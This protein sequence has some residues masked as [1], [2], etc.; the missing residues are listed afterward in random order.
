[1][2]VE[3]DRIFALT[4]I[5][6]EGLA[7]AALV[8]RRNFRQFP[9]F[10]LYLAWAI[11]VDIAGYYLFARNGDLYT[12]LYPFELVID[13]IFQFGILFE[14]SRSVLRPV[15]RFLPRW[16][17]IALGLLIL[18]LGGAIW[19]IAHQLNTFSGPYQNLLR[20]E[21]AFSILRILYFFA[22]AGLS[23]FLSLSWRDRELQIA[24]GLGIYSMVSVTVSVLHTRPAFSSGPPAHRLEQV[25]VA[26]YACSLL[27]WI[28]SFAQ[29]EAE[30]R[31]FTPQM[32]GFLL[33]LAGNARTTRVAMTDA[34]N[35]GRDSDPRR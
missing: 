17:S 22:L 7:L 26:S 33:A 8:F 3:L 18:V 29:K 6:E 16:F 31:E 28:V 34:R 32:Q 9:I 1:L 11:V 10:C 30:R 27:Y 12:R 23:Q 25:V 20:I 19:L 24:T 35:S 14:L 13:S 2:T 15:A 21:N 5:A 4:G